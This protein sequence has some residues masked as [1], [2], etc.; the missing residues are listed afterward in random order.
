MS[1]EVVS[2]IH[3][4][5]APNTPEVLK[6]M[7]ALGDAL[8]STSATHNKVAAD[9]HEGIVRSMK[10]T[11]CEYKQEVCERFA[12]GVDILKGTPTLRD[13][14][15]AAMVLTA[16]ASGKSWDD[17]DRVE[18]EVFGLNTNCD[19]FG[20]LAENMV[21]G[22]SHKTIVDNQALCIAVGNT[23]NDTEVHTI[24]AC[25]ILVLAAV[26][27]NV[28]SD[29][30]MVPLYS[31]AY[32]EGFAEYYEKAGGVFT[33]PK[34]LTQRVETDNS[35]NED[36][37][38]KRL[39][40]SE[41]EDAE[42]AMIDAKLLG[43]GGE[44]VHPDARGWAH[45]HHKCGLTSETLIATKHRF[46]LMPESS[47]AIVTNTFGTSLMKLSFTSS[48][49]FS[50]EMRD[51]C[52]SNHHDPIRNC[53]GVW[54]KNADT[55]KIDMCAIELGK[56]DL[57]FTV[58]NVAS[59]NAK[60]SEDKPVE[61]I[62]DE[63]IQDVKAKKPIVA[64]ST[65]LYPF[66]NNKDVSGVYMAN[67]CTGYRK[68][69][70]PSSSFCATKGIGAGTRSCA[71]RGGGG[72]R[73]RTPS[74]EVFC[75]EEEDLEATSD[76]KFPTIGAGLPLYEMKGLPAY[77]ANTMELCKPS[78]TIM[79][80]LVYAGDNNTSD[81]VSPGEA[82]DF[83]AVE[84]VE[85]VALQIRNFNKMTADC[86]SA[87]ISSMKESA[88]LIKKN[89]LTEQDHATLEATKTINENSANFFGL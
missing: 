67:L 22:C 78:Y 6:S 79:S 54:K 56:S 11:F 88:L 48:G 71:T 80:V 51:N 2:K 36:R 82:E 44:W 53:S 1:H 4:A 55:G 57:D 38:A 32:F 86:A 3:T 15:G 23:R 12:R 41:E 72:R 85:A 52:Y 49:M 61:E 83:R 9:A 69:R 26:G 20:A 33:G 46:M 75:E 34:S 8:H 28:A 5:D 16:L 47:L 74:P 63:P 76:I 39:K 31:K 50:L 45:H 84:L 18:G 64:P 29:Q 17:A 42:A 37:A 87:V 89:T 10:K 68:I 25:G 13:H 43:E 40:T 27:Q 65:G 70:K 24:P 58:K 7:A 59:M 81:A 30:R 66:L 73:V 21:A 77:D 35:N 14:Y 62:K 19:T 60:M